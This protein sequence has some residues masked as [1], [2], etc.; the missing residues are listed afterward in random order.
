MKKIAIHCTELNQ[1]RID[2]T[3]VYLSRLLH[4]FHQLN[5]QDQFLLYH[6]G[7]FNPE[8]EPPK[9][10]N[11]TFKNLNSSFSFWTQTK[12]AWEI[13]KEK[14]DVLWMPVQDLPVFRREK[15]KTFVTAHDL[16]FKLFPET[17]PKK[18]LQKLNLLADYSFQNADKI[19][20]VS[21]T[22]KNDLLRF[23]PKIKEENIKVIHHGFDT[24]FWQEN[25][26]EREVAKI[27]KKY[28]L[29][30]QEYLIS[31]GAIQ[32]RKNLSFLIKVFEKV[33]KNYPNLKLVLAGGNGWL[34]DEIFETAKKSLFSSDIV[35]TNMIS[36]EVMRI[37][38]QNSKL[39]IYPALYEGFGI[40]VLESMASGIPTICA[41]NSSFLEVGGEAVCFFET[42][43]FEDCKEKIEGILKNFDLQN[44]M[45]E[46]GLRQVKDFSWEKCAR[47]TLDFLLS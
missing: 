23:Y 26:K 25:L 6:K 31:V 44:K 8:L 37:L 21:K 41:N 22:T 39:A 1:Q 11:Y 3:R 35:F 2:G 13:F 14:P 4:Y 24:N 42:N 33:K 28:N 47:E 29:E 43:D 9:A 5:S 27:L 10:R 20:A 16:A 32:P 45:R 18:D 7:K 40:P 19:I 12:F 38:L 15:I 34:C 17:F 46:R 30:K 36:F